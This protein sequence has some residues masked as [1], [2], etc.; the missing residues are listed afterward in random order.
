MSEPFVVPKIGSAGVKQVEKAVV[1]GAI[2]VA[3]AGNSTIIIT[4]NGLAGS[5][6]TVN[7]PVANSDPASTVAGKIRSA[8]AVDLDVTAIFDISG[9]GVNL[10]LTSKTPVA[11]DA[12]LNISIANGTCSGLVAAPTSTNV[13]K[14]EARD[15]SEI[16]AILDRS[17]ASTTWAASTQVN[18]GDLRLPTVRNGRQY[19]AIKSGV[20]GATEPTW[21]FSSSS[22]FQS[23]TIGSRV[24][25]GTAV[26]EDYGTQDN[27][28]DI[29]QAAHEVW[30]K[31]CARSS[32]YVS[33]PGIDMASIY[34]R[35]VEMRDRFEPVLIA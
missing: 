16:E 15:T 19:R 27:E 24:Y 13:T 2:G 22:V 12:T 3:G 32:Q 31:K 1:A 23:S 30:D 28:Y 17:R 35:C 8:F 26:F 21:S 7:V 33:T 5:P 18:V 11:N 25:D 10:I 4:A 6:K 34:K 20:T 9:V 29:W 14:G